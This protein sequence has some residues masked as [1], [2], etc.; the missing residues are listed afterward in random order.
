MGARG[1][2]SAAAT[3]VATLET[4]Q[5]K[6]MAANGEKQMAVDR[7]LR[8]LLVSDGCRGVPIPLKIRWMPAHGA[9]SHAIDTW[10]TR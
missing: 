7:H 6:Q 8:E 10:H 2:T 3:Q 1:E 4:R 5:A 9:E